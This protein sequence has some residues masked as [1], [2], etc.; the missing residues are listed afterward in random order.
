MSENLP[1]I[2]L[3]IAAMGWGLSLF[4]YRFF[5]RRND[6]PMGSAHA[7][8]P[9]I[10]TI[11][12]GAAVISAIVFAASLGAAEGG[13]LIV[14]LGSLLA[15]LWTGIARV[16]SQVSLFLAPLAMGFLLFGWLAGPILQ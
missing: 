14:A 11:V 12:G 15:L 16:G 6:W 5:A 3:A 2:L 10:P 7:N 4:T 13:W 1:L 8:A 9:A